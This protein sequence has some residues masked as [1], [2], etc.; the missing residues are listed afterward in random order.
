MSSGAQFKARPLDS[1][2]SNPNIYAGVSQPCN[3]C[4]SGVGNSL[5]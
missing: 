4:H 3:Y 2:V 1:A 5:L